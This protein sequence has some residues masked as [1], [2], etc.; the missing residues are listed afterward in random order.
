[1]VIGIL[2]ALW[3]NN[4][5]QE[6]VNTEERNNLKIAIKEELS[7][8]KEFFNDYKTYTEQCSKK[9]VTILNVSAGENTQIPIDTLRKYAVEMMLIRAFAIDESRRNS[10]KSAGLLKRLNSEESAVLADYETILENYKEARK[11]NT[12]WKEENR[13][14]FTFSQKERKNR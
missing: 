8:N 14:L 3:L 12:I 7:E 9:I 13:I 11:I 2:I 4:L 6:R 10:A 5:N 1:M